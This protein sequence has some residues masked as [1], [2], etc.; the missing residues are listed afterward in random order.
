V[1]V[2]EDRKRLPALSIAAE[3]Y[4]L[5]AGYAAENRISVSEAV[6]DLLADSPKLKA[7]A[8]KQGKPV[9]LAVNVWGGYRERKDE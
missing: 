7:F 4:D 2:T 1:N 5:L 3:G 9:K 8:K 6:R